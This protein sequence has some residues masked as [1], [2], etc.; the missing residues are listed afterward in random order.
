M[1]RILRISDIVTTE[2]LFYDVEFVE[3]CYEFC[4]L[5]DIQILP[6]LEDQ[7]KIYIRDDNSKNFI[8]DEICEDW[9]VESFT[10]AFN[11][12]ILDAFKK[13]SILFIY[14][15]TE[16]TGVLH[17]SDFNKSIVSEYLFQELFQYER[18]L[19]IYLLKS[20]FCNYDIFA[21]LKKQLGTS[22][23]KNCDA[24]IKKDFQYKFANKEKLPPLQSFYLKDLIGFANALGENLYVEVNKLRNAVMHA[25]ELVDKENWNEE[26]FIFDSKSFEEFF[27]YVLMLHRDY[28]KIKNKIAFNQVVNKNVSKT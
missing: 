16:F 11:P 18:M 27:T 21:Y 14:T 22:N 13:N 23:E 19:R 6:S 28:K 8:E 3:K 12:I 4:K 9:K 20:G 1:E 17:F 15:G 2:V 10:N 5:R 25:H 24:K 7:T 26:N